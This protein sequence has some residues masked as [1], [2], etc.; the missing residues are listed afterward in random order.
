MILV[1]S[2]LSAIVLANLSS[3]Y[4]GPVASPINAFLFIGLNITLRDR[5]HEH[6]YGSRL[7]L[8]TVGLISAGSLI[9]YLLNQDSVMICIA[10]ITAFSAAMAT[11]FIIYEALIKKSRF[12]KVNGSNVGSS[13]VDSV[14]FPT[15]AFGWMPW[16]IAAQFLAKFIGGYIWF[17]ALNR[18]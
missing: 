6:W 9:T 12:V 18:K 3:T 7:M 17:L 13:V 2:F 10:S 8:K 1:F 14:I 15:I 4:F 11:D 5:L 16:V